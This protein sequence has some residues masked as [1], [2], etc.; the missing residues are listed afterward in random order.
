MKKA[1][2]NKRDG[3]PMYARI[4]EQ[5]RS[6]IRAGKLKIGDRLESERQLAARH[7]VSLMTARQAMTGL[8]RDGLVER[9]RGSGTYVSAPR[10]NWNQLHSFTEEMRARGL[11]GSSRLLSTTLVRADETAAAHL[12]VAPGAPLARIERLRLGAG[13]PLA[14]EDCK[15][16]LDRF[17]HLLNHHFE[18]ASLFKILEQEY[19]VR[20]ARAE[21]TIEAQPASK[22]IA[23]LLAIPVGSPVLYLTQ[24]LCTSHSEPIAVATAWYRGDRH[25]FRIVRTRESGRIH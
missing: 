5:I 18:S 12:G 7:S 25:H 14:V 17:P 10:I 15:L 6:G 4:Y 9:R 22:R 19:G 20:I 8:E 24:V 16:P 13:E 2:T 11:E 1:S 21:E 23:G 3:V